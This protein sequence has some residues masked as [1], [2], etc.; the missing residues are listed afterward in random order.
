M[1][2]GLDGNAPRLICVSG[3]ES[4]QD[5]THE[6]RPRMDTGRQAENEE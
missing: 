1:E 6:G 5:Y 3:S 4:T 2:N